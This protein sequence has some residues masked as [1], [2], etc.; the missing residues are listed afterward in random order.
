MIFFKFRYFGFAPDFTYH[1]LFIKS[2][3]PLHTESHCLCFEKFIEPEQK[4]M[5]FWGK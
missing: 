4:L 5:L 2:R 3:E 1:K